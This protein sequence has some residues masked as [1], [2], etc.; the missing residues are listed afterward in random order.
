MVSMLPAEI[1]RA[2]EIALDGRVL[3]VSVAVAVVAGLAASLVPALRASRTSPGAA[4]REGG[5]GSSASARR[6]RMSAAMVVVQVTAA[7]VLVTG[8]GLLIRTLGALAQVDPG[9]AADTVTTARLTLNPEGYDS[10]SERMDLFAQIIEGVEA[11]PGVASAAAAGHV[12]FGPGWSG[13]ATFIEDVTPDPNEL[14]FMRHTEVTPGYFESM[15]IPLLRGRAIDGTDRAETELVAVVDETMAAQFW[16]DTN[17][18]G[19]R[20]RYPWR[21]APWITVVGVV[22]G[23]AETTLDADRAP[24]FYVPMSQRPPYAISLVARS[25]D[26]SAIDIAGIQAVVDGID[27]SIPMSGAGPLEGFLATS[28]ARARWSASLVAA[29]AALTL[30]LGCIGVYGVVAYSVGE[31]TRDF[32]VQMA[33]GAAPSRIRRGVLVQGLKLALPGAL[34]GLLVAVPATRALESMLYGVAPL[35]PFTFAAV[36]TMLVLATLVA[37]Y[38]PSRRA[39]R[40]DPSTALRADL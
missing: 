39:T 6:R 8:A 11:L 16:P 36:P 33:L 30:L 27:G 22:G 15:G 2:G 28:M 12:P 40:V 5:R 24:A 3:W 19:K 10:A 1:P 35:D 25:A 13:M 23:T 31:R 18:I 29:F 7:V 4:L 26:G 17:P 37:C 20:V 21:G 34:L 14:P 38:V 32:G 9:F